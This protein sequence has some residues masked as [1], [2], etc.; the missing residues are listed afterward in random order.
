M[1]QKVYLAQAEAQLITETLKAN[2]ALRQ[3]LLIWQL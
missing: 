3:I 2:I 1:A